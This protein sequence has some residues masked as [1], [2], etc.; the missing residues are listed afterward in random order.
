M[1]RF[2][3]ALT[4]LGSLTCLSGAQEAEKSPAPVNF[5]EHVFPIFRQHCLQC[6]NAND[7][8]AGLA[9]DS[10]GALMEGS[11]SGDVVAEGDSGSSRLYLVMTHDE[12]PA[13]PPDQDPIPAEQLDIIKRWIDGGLLEN[14]G[15]KARKRKGPSLS[16]SM[17]DSGKPDEIIMPDQVWRV[18]VVTSQRSAAAT[19][20]AASPWAPLVAVAGQKQ[21]A[22]YHTESNDLLG[23]IPYPE[24]IPQVLRFNRD[25]GYL[26]V[27]G[28][29][30]ASMGTASLYDVRNGQRL[31]SVGDELDVVFGADINDSM[32]RI[33]L[34]G[35]QKM[36]RIFD[37]DSGDA[38]FE[39]KKHTDWVYCVDYSPDGVL[40][41]SGDRSGGLHVW[42]AETGR[43]YLDLI[44]HKGAVRSLVWRA[45]SNVLLSASEDG[46]VKMWEMNAGNQ[47]KSFNAHSGGVT[48]IAMG[49]DGKIVTSGKDRTVK[50]WNADGSAV[51]TMPA[52]SEP[53][54][55]VAIS[56]D[57]SRVIGG[58]WNGRTLMWQ[59]SDPKINTELLANPPSLTQQV[60]A[61]DNQVQQLASSREDI[62]KRQKAGQQIIA[63]Y[64]KTEESLGS[65]ITDAKTA[66]S[67]ASSK[68]VEAENKMKALQV[69]TKDLNTTTSGLKNKIAEMENQLTSLKQMELSLADKVKQAIVRR[70]AAEVDAAKAKQLLASKLNQQEELKVKVATTSTNLLKQEMQLLAKI[71]LSADELA[72]AQ[73]AHKA[74][75]E[76][77][78][79]ATK[80]IKQSKKVLESHAKKIADLVIKHTELGK[81]LIQNNNMLTNANAA[82]TETESEMISIREKIQAETTEEEK[83]ALTAQLKA[84]ETDLAEII[85]K[86]AQSNE[87]IGRIQVETKSVSTDLAK[88][89]AAKGEED[90]TLQKTV[91]ENSAI[92]EQ[93]S[94]A[95]AVLESAKNS[96]TGL[97]QEM[98]AFKQQM[99]KSDAEKLKAVSTI[100]K[101]IAE[102]QPIEQRL[103]ASSST[104]TSENGK[105]DGFQQEIK[106]LA[107]QRNDAEA[108]KQKTVQEFD[109][110][111]ASLVSMKEELQGL[112]GMIQSYA[113][114]MT[115]QQ[116]AISSLQTTLAESITKR[117]ASQ[118]T[119]QSVDQE[120]VSVDSELNSANQKL[121]A[122]QEE[123]VA[124]E[125]TSKRLRDE[126][127]KAALIAQQ[128]R[129]ELDPLQK[130][131]DGLATS[132]S[133]RA[134]QMET[135]SAEMTR[136]QQELAML[137][138]A[139]QEAKAAQEQAQKK[140]DETSAAFEEIEAAEQTAKEKLEFFESAYGA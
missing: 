115:D 103:A 29:T 93:I 102:Q 132:I 22:L 127:E 116:A 66:V 82:K 137:E 133:D 85:N 139:Q 106:Q 37:T 55:E 65:K 27:A 98:D 72:V 44:G 88:S 120:L 138:K 87:A 107:T 48:G 54:L 79:A 16:F 52:F 99:S 109:T 91:A 40:V 125:S 100:A 11:G 81:A 105:M 118:K 35:P 26:L 23:V 1:Q 43:L 25:G 130:G 38:V 49:Q 89:K 95:L 110:K 7:A 67:D 131:V 80:A 119:L 92:G 124:F 39:L 56:H 73:Q 41:A 34:G 2:V 58:D 15:S 60:A 96:H 31:L 36:V 136:I 21:V 28:G 8:E 101:L 76:K 140:L 10:F 12:E 62:L 3:L 90:K 112:P 117:E 97:T 6:H 63:A 94:S 77:S 61:Q 70:D 20:I 57:S 86:V 121:R 4:I 122:L 113:K 19:A 42:E 84:L 50:V 123:L 46:T 14:S 135:A 104:V 30:H 114:S 47:L 24:G 53:A 45:D 68:K 74:L 71:Q 18:P 78:D 33:A 134:K 9:L 111:S 108:L 32:T 59:I 13:M 75:V 83:V 51:A 128:K 5:E 129:A 126:A 64:L 17:S 69:Q